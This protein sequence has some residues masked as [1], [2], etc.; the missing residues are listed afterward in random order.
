MICHTI[1]SI[2]EKGLLVIIAILSATLPLATAAA[3][4][5]ND[6]SFSL[7]VQA[8]ILYGRSEEIVYKYPDSDI[9]S[10][11]LLWDLKPLVYT[12]LAA[13]FGPRDPYSRNGLAAALSVKVGLPLKT[14]IMEDRDWLSPANNYITHY[15]HHDAFSRRAVLADASLGY[16]WNL[17]GFL[18]LKAYG[19][20]SYMNFLW[21][22]ENG[23]LQYPADDPSGNYPEWNGGLPKDYESSKG[24]VIQY[25][26]NWFIFSP[27]LSLAA[28]FNRFF[29]VEGTFNYS[30]L[31]YCAGRDD[32]V[33]RGVVFSD[34]LYYGHYLKGSAAVIFS[35]GRNIDI[36]LGVAY[37]YI[38]GPRG[39]S[40]TEQFVFDDGAGAAYSALDAGLAV[41]YTFG[42]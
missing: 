18:A 9:Y 19:E 15:S 31:I 4:E 3:A 32:H 29:S 5:I 13:D 25:G 34:Y 36:S 27:G 42:K 21:S 23:Y 12:G 11:E 8:G 24:T 37:S 33:K 35:T 6:K 26:Q 2:K 28:K 22:A 39:D 30:P 16:S 14:G 40:R 17:A 38:T 10:S 7:S 1:T 41:K 20:F